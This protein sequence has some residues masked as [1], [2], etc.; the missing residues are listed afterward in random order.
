[1][2]TWQDS[3]LEYRSLDEIRNEQNHRLQAHIAYLAANS[4][5]YRRI[6]AENG[7]EAADIQTVDDMTKL[8]FTVKADLER[9]N[10]EL[11]C[12]PETEIVDLCQTSGTTGQPVVLM[13]T[14]NDL[15]RLAYNESISFA[16][17]GVSAADR[18]AIVCHLGRNFMAGLAYFLGV[19]RL[20]ATAIRTGSD[21]LP[22]VID[23]IKR[24]RPS[25]IVSVPSV[26]LAIAGRLRDSGVDPAGLGVQRIICIGEPIRND[27]F[28][29]STLGRNLYD[30]WSAQ[31]YATYA[32][33]EMAT[34]FCDCDAQAGGHH[35][36]DL[37]VLELVDDDGKPVPDGEL[38]EVVA[39]PLGVTGMPLL[40]LK[41]GDLARLHTSPCDCGRRS[42]RLGPIIGRRSQMLKVRGCTVYPPAIFAALQDF[43]QIQ[44][45][46]I[47][48]YDDYDLSDRVKVVIGATDP[49]LKADDVA[50]QIA[51]RTR[52]KPQV[53]IKTPDEVR[54]T[55][56]VKD[57]RKPVTFFDHRRTTR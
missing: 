15:D 9:A 52:A 56:I 46:Y 35:H 28:T 24:Y 23:S 36:P 37:V 2:S 16:A 7:I 55:I 13:Q 5:F 51:A 8:P 44:G 27:D 33:T 45:A 39:T 38:G 6:F 26:A 50:A 12:V 47:E 18:V 17:C 54:A 25:V 43:P 40:R 49:T 34:A 41:T 3:D 14:R 32:S 4:P 10:E 42:V 11:L 53:E 30:A 29:L 22:M 57:M 21:S 31:I 1:M 19:S 20:G 48:V